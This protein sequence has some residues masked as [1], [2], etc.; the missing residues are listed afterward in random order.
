MTKFIKLTNLKDSES[1]YINVE[2]IGHIYDV[3]EEIQYGR[4]EVERHTVVGSTC[5]NNGG[6]KVKE[7]TK[8]IFKLIEDIRK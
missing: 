2:F 7:T 8:Q 5:H 1:I 3:K 6:F 4:V